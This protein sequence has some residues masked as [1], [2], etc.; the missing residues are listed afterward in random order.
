M[1]AI[2]EG[3]IISV[4]LPYNL[5]FLQYNDTSPDKSFHHGPFVGQWFMQASH[6][7]RLHLTPGLWPFAACL[8]TLSVLL[9][10]PSSLWIKA[11]SPLEFKNNKNK[12][13]HIMFFSLPLLF[14]NITSIWEFKT[15]DGIA[16]VKYFPLLLNIRLLLL[17][18]ALQVPP[19]TW[20]F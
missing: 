20:I 11:T 17:Y 1:L 16:S 19:L 4:W 6:V 15:P 9:S 10:C 3:A 13:F 18:S 7:W 12:S 5:R 14:N 2:C 8:C